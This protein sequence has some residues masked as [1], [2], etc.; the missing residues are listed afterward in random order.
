MPTE[1]FRERHCSVEEDGKDGEGSGRGLTL[2]AIATIRLEALSK[3]IKKK[4]RTKFL[5]GISQFGVRRATA[6]THL[7]C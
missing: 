3:T 1:P 6:C 7:F 4:L 5:P 2:G